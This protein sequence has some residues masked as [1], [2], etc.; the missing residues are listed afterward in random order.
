M[1]NHTR[2]RERTSS[3]TGKFLALGIGVASATGV[4]LVLASEANAADNTSL[5]DAIA[6]CESSGNPNA[7]NGTHFGL[8]QFDLA[9]WRSVGGKGDPR[10]AST[11]E[12]YARATAL[13]A[14]RGT[15]PWLASQ[16]CWS[17]KVGKAPSLNSVASSGS[18][19]RANLTHAKPS[20][21]PRSSRGTS[22]PSK[23][24]PKPVTPKV[25]STTSKTPA[26]TISIPV[27]STPVH[28]SVAESSGPRTHTVQRGDY[29]VKIAAQYGMNWKT[30]W[31][32]NRDQVSNPNRIYPNQVLRL[33]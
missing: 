13:L 14:S 27:Q 3:T 25:D 22:T 10:N 12:Q 21:T 29:L 32:L 5:L 28:D 23:N 15:Q 11:S 17:G 18:S 2:E 20:P 24:T 6:Q 1:G 8:F 31:N 30:L 19:A 33:K 9:T 4:P 26:P 16:H 7:S